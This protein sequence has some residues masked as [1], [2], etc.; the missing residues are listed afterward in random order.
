MKLLSKKN[1][2]DAT[3]FIMWKEVASGVELVTISTLGYEAKKYHNFASAIASS[4][5]QK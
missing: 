3:Y 5:C 2:R 1:L 4:L